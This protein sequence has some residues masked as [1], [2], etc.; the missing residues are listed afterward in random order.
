MRSATAW[1]S[2]SLS[3]CSRSDLIH[4]GRCS[5]LTIVASNSWADVTPRMT[6]IRERSS[7]SN[8]VPR[9]SRSTC[10]ATIKASSWDVSV[11]GTMLGGT[12]HPIASKS[13]LPRKPPRRA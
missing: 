3:P 7:E 13:T 4:T 8:W 5:R 10:S 12:P 2:A 1:T 11:A 6:D 9:A